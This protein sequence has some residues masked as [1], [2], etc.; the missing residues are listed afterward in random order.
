MKVKLIG[1]VRFTSKKNNKE[2][3]SLNFLGDRIPEDRGDGWFVKNCIVTPE[4]VPEDLKAGDVEIEKSG[5]S[6][7]I[8]AIKNIEE[9]K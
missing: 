4:I 7:Y 6:D 5:W 8:T 9:K 2:Y 1:W 3:V